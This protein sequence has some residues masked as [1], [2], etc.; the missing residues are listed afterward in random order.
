MGE[1]GRQWMARSYS[2]TGVADAM[3]QVYRWLAGD[4]DV[5]EHVR[6]G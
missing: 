4:A 5:P 3:S 1:R 2:W 6:L